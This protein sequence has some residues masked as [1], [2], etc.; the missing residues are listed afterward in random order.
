MNLI[1]KARTVLNVSLSWVSYF[2]S[3]LMPRSKEIWIFLGWHKNNT[4]EV[5]ADNSK[6]LFLNVANNHPNIRPIW[7]SAD[8]KISNLLRSKG[9]ESYSIN[10]LSGIYYSLRAK[11]TILGANM[12]TLNWRLSGRTNII[13]LWHGDGVKQMQLITS[14][15]KW[16]FL[17]ISKI[18]I[19]P[20]LLRKVLFFI[21]ASEH[22]TRKFIC[23][24]FNT[25]ID[26]VQITGLPRTDIFF[27]EIPGAEIDIDADLEKKIKQLQTTKPK[28]LILYAPTFRR[29]KDP[30]SPLSQLKFIELEKY[31]SE[32]NYHLIISL[33]PKFSKSKWL[34][35][36]KFQHI[37]FSNPG[38]DKYPLLKHFDLLVTDYSSIF[39]EF[40][41]L[42]IPTIFHVYDMEEYTTVQ[43]I[44]QD[45]WENIP[46]LRT[47]TFN[48][49][50]SVMDLELEELKQGHRVA[51]EKLFKYK[52][53][54]SSERVT[55]E[56]LKDMNS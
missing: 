56:I 48:E 55:Q 10:S 42:D 39:M 5:F 14:N 40:L 21:S 25:Q 31:L 43:G 16:S 47:K 51:R 32:R 54:Y 41:L 1:A 29:G 13:Q 6:Y 23:P 2:L 37:H 18:F 34:P 35:E 49:L 9:Y 30:S 44:H 15:S 45:M 46:G 8:E 24:S 36:E 28:R 7:I 50:L 17:K 19:A 3:H 52:D 53:A 38:L 12:N 20:S 26:K 27:S 33:H 22:A 11:Y 4:R